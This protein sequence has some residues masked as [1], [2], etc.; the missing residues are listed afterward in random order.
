MTK[1]GVT[2]V[3]DGLV[4]QGDPD[5]PTPEQAAAAAQQQQ[6]EGQPE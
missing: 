5:V 2:F 4:G 3:A 1:F 6:E